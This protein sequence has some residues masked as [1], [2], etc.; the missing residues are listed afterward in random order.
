MFKYI[1]S[2]LWY[3][4]TICQ[5]ITFVLFRYSTPNSSTKESKTMAPTNIWG[6]TRAIQNK[7]LSCGWLILRGCETQG[8]R[9]PGT[10]ITTANIIKVSENIHIAPMNVI[11]RRNCKDNAPKLDP[12]LYNIKLDLMSQKFQIHSSTHSFTIQ[13]TEFTEH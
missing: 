4:I 2:S 8:L 9:P 6:S 3:K 1:T 10:M 7:S 11:R 13:R 12:N 5:F